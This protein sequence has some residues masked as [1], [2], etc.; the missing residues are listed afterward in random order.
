MKGAIFLNLKSETSLDRYDLNLAFE[1]HILYYY[2]ALLP[3][4]DPIYLFSEKIPT[5]YETTDD[6]DYS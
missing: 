6:S 4:L 1:Y 2:L 5:C 3:V